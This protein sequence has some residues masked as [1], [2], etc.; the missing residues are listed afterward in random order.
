MDFQA[1][2]ECLPYSLQWVLR[3]ISY[4]YT[5]QFRKG[6]PPFR[7]I[8]PMI[9]SSKETAVLRQEVSSLLRKGAIEKVHPSQTV[10]F[11]QPIFCCAQITA[12]DQYWIYAV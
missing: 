10:R 3:T 4:G 11:L 2:W 5:I 1:T 7:W 6:P 8:L 12:Y 9:V